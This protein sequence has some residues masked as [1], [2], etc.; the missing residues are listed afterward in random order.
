M[1]I[2]GR[3]SLLDH[4]VS[5]TGD[6]IAIVMTHTKGEGHKDIHQLAWEAFLAGTQVAKEQGLY[7]AGQ[8]LLKD[9]F[10]GNV[11]GMGPVA[12]LL[13][14]PERYVIESV[15]ARATGG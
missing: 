10:S 8:D 9:A 13:R 4:Y 11:R 2:Q 15:W 12:A 5:F 3:Q 7:G 1:E 14:N 6:E